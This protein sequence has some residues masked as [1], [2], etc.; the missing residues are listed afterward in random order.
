PTPDR[1]RI[2]KRNQRR[3]PILSVSCLKYNSKPVSFSLRAFTT[4]SARNSRGALE[5]LLWLASYSEVVR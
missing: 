1:S 2:E 5:S 3:L 4:L